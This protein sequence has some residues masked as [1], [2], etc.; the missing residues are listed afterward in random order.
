VSSQLLEEVTAHAQSDSLEDVRE[1]CADGN[2]FLNNLCMW[3]SDL[4]TLM[5]QSTRQTVALGEVVHE[6]DVCMYVVTLL[7]CEMCRAIKI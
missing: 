3:L 1:I 6:F 2:H 4:V 7:P 5:A